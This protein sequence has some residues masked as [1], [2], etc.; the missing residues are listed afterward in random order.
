MK[1]W[2]T[3]SSEVLFAQ[4][5]LLTLE[6]RRLRSS[7][8]PAGGGE[9]DE[10]DAL[11]VES[12]DWV[13][14]VP[15]L[16]DGRLVLIRQW[17]YGSASFQLEFPGGIVEEADVESAARRELA[18]ETG[19]RASRLEPLGVIDPNPAIQSNRL[20]V[21]RATGLERI[22]EPQVPAADEDEEIEL[23]PLDEGEIP[24]M[25]ARGEI[26]HALVLASFYLHRLQPSGEGPE[27]A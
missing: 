12:G 16:A 22:P 11:V 3:V 10:R 7:E 18:E 25:I 6:R 23:L 9:P 27:G 20:H 4:A 21:F 14:V 5:P 2:K 1:T 26:S 13:H 15:V 8:T 17:R 19:F 24:G